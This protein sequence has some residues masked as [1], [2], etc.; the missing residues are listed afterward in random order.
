M[1]V[2]ILA[3]GQGKRLRPLT[4]KLPKCM[5]EVEGKTILEHQIQCL[6]RNGLFDINI[7]VGYASHK[8]D[9]DS[10]LYHYNPNYA[11]TNMVYTLFCAR[12]ILNGDQDILISYGD[13]IYNDKV[14][15]TIINDNSKIGIVVDKDWF[16]YWSD[17]M[18]NPLDDAETL[19]INDHGYISEIGKKPLS[20][21]DIQGQYIG[22]IKIKADLIS[23]IISLYE[24]LDK[25]ETYDGNDFNNMYM[26][27]FLQL[28]SE[29]IAPLNPVFINNGWI[30]IDIPSD[31]LLTKYLNY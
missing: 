13:I 31:L 8:I 6:K 4:N 9:Y 16:K 11:K 24:S 26:T 12:E 27:T 2:V 29:S 3:A 25:N 20:Y 23:S 14:I 19:K 7:C 15:K 22:L 5:V 10:V 1:K 28:I 30:E 17:R 18:E 21:N